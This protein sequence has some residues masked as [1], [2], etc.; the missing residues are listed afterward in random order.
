MCTDSGCLLNCTKMVTIRTYLINWC[1]FNLIYFRQILL[2]IESMYISLSITENHVLKSRCIPITK[3]EMS[4]FHLL[5]DV[6]C[7]FC[8]SV[9][10][11]STFLIPSSGILSK[12]FFFFDLYYFNGISF[13]HLQYVILYI[14]IAPGKDFL[15]YL[16]FLLAPMLKPSVRIHVQY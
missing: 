5:C 1:E 2:N 11:D 15:L 14:V 12:L 6:P 10:V 3:T 4:S 8:R 13:R 7:M 9:Y 16:L